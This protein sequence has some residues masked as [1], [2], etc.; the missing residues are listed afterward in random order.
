MKIKKVMKAVGKALTI[1]GTAVTLCLMF[2]AAALYF[3]IQWMFDTWS[4]LSMDE[5]V[6]HLSTSLD[7]TSTDMIMEYLGTCVAPAIVL[8]LAC[9]FVFWGLR[10]K[11]RYYIVMLAGIIAS[12]TTSYSNVR[13]AWNELGADDYVRSQGIDSTFVEDYYVSPAEVT[14]TFPEKKRNLIYIFLESME[15]T[16]ADK[17]NGGAFDENVIPEL[18]R[19]AQENEDFS[20]DSRELN[21]GHSLTGS[22]W[23]IGAMFSQTAGIPLSI[24]I[25]RNTMN[26]Q[27]TFFSG[28]IT[29]GDI[30]R[31]AGYSQTLMIGSD[32]TFGGRRL[33]FTEHGNYEMVDYV[34]AAEQEWIPEGY[35]V[36]W[37]YEDE[38]LFEFAKQQ[39]LAAAGGEEPFNF[40]M[41]TVDT[42]FEDGYVCGICPDTYGEDQ[43]AN[44]MACSSSQLADF[45]NWIKRQDFYENTTVVICG[46]HPTMDK[47][48]CEDI[49]AEYQRKTYVAYVNSAA[50]CKS[51]KRRIYTTFDHF[52]TTLAAM[53][54]K[55]EGDRLGLGTNLFSG[56][57]TLTE[58]I[59]LKNEQ[60]ELGKRSRFLEDMAS[61]E[62]EEDA[63]LNDAGKL[64][65]AT[66]TAGT[67]DYSTGIMA[68]EVHNFINLDKKIGSM[69]LAVWTKEDQSDMQWIQMSRMGQEDGHYRAEI[70]VP[71]FGFE[72]GE[73]QI[74]A[75]VVDEDGEQYFVGK[76]TGIVQ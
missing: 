7:G 37:G 60:E 67:Y 53:G 28:A 23:T 75:Y 68:V 27:E 10:G 74:H 42:H 50:E 18:T 32:A 22:T 9:M 56:R 24:A 2:G 41:L 46:D 26:T 64:V 47:N 70:N 73:Y 15:T 6:Y 59:G 62:L 8:F 57:P 61:L 36:W 33:Y 25:D 14:L 19:I 30:L 16:Y 52:P 72:E 38:K 63:M 76:T 1:I 51:D 31:Q 43:Y 44:V 55:I 5:L 54:I 35:R 66:V 3:S 12:V 39:L 17:E 29:L 11:K 69:L 45:L 71:N 48:F 4:N 34:Y 21:G 58:K 40:T 20:G 13:A 65:T 49:D